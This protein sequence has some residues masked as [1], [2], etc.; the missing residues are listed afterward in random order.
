R[1][2]WDLLEDPAF[3]I[4]AIDDAYFH[5]NG[6]SVLTISGNHVQWIEH[7]V[8]A[9]M[10]RSFHHGG[11]IRGIDVSP[12]G[13]LLLTYGEDHLVQVW[14]LDS[15]SYDNDVDG[16]LLLE[17]SD[18]SDIALGNVTRATFSPKSDHVLIGMSSGAVQVVPLPHI[19]SRKLSETPVVVY[20]DSPDEEFINANN[21]TEIL[22]QFQVAWRTRGD[23]LEIEIRNQ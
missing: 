9:Q 11:P 15:A 5:P 3:G 10:H 23:L 6:E 19:V 12:D 17:T 20:Y 8:V 13:N 1:K 2:L 14:D 18:V 16:H 7:D 21:L 22:G 4:G